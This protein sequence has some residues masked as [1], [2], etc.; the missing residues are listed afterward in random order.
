MATLLILRNTT[1]GG[2]LRNSGNE[3]VRGP[4]TVSITDADF[5]FASDSSTGA[6]FTSDSFNRADFTT[7]GGTNTDAAAGGTATAWTT[8]GG[9]AQILTN[10]A[11]LLSA[12]PPGGVTVDT[13]TTDHVVSAKYTSAPANNGTDNYVAAR[14]VDASNYYFASVR[15][16]SPGVNQYEFKKRVAGTDTHLGASPY[17]SPTPTINDI[18][19]LQVVGSVVSMFVNGTL[20]QSVSDTSLAAGT[21]VGIGSTD[22]GNAFRVDDFLVVGVASGSITSDT[23]DADTAAAN[24]A[25]SGGRTTSD[26]DTVAITDA[27]EAITA[28]IADADTVAATDAGESVTVGGGGNVFVTDG[29]TATVIDDATITV[30]VGDADTASAADT[31]AAYNFV[32]GPQNRRLVPQ[33]LPASNNFQR[34]SN[35]MMRHFDTHLQAE[36][37]LWLLTDGTVT[38]RQPTDASLIAKAWYGGH[39]NVLTPQEELI[40]LAAGYTVLRVES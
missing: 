15:H 32:L 34:T 37:N 38:T 10:S 23:T 17:T 36:D 16:V 40:L 12:G 6:T 33:V 19:K 18:I 21:K 28:T 13:G 39:T 27:G 8:F 35:R 29:D 7:I 25:Q 26:A 1:G 24:D 3:L 22:A 14:F 9:G 31:N 4:S 20:I 2:Y 30:S 5:A 11:R